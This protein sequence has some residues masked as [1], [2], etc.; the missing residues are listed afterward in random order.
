MNFKQSCFGGKMLQVNAMDLFLHLLNWMLSNMSVARQN[1]LPTNFTLLL[2]D[3]TITHAAALST[4]QQ[5][6]ETDK[7]HVVLVNFSTFEDK[8][9]N[10]NSL[11][12]LHYFYAMLLSVGW[13]LPAQSEVEGR[14][15]PTLMLLI[16]FGSNF[17]ALLTESIRVAH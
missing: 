12:N 16:I 17:P 10:C 14:S 6:F 9:K 8:N 3:K 5:L 13:A 1:P 4:H 11:I 15:D 2:A 7:K